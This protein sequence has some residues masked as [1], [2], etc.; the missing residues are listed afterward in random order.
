MD[1]NADIRFWTQRHRALFA[2]VAEGIDRGEAPRQ[3]T[4]AALQ[5][6]RGLL[7]ELTLS[8]RITAEV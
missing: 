8:R 4:V 2:K 6:V 5:G 1:R 3:E 7:E